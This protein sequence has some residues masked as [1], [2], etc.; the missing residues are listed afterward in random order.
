MAMKRHVIKLPCDVSKIDLSK[1][2]ELLELYDMK[3]VRAYDKTIEIL[4]PEKLAGLVI[5]IEEEI[6]RMCPKVRR[7]IERERKRLEYYEKV[8]REAM[9]ESRLSE[10]EIDDIVNRVLRDLGI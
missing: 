1:V 7:K 5:D 10:K 9:R 2:K 8:Y 3:L 4:Y 6:K